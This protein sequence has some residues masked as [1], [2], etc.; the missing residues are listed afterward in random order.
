VFGLY[1]QLKLKKSGQKWYDKE[2]KKLLKRKINY[3]FLIK[4]L[5]TKLDMSIS[6][7]YIFAH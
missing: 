3:I 1:F 7:I 2:L 5:K 4:Q 6:E